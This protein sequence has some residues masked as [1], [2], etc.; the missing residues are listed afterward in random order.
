MKNITHIKTAF[1]LAVMLNL[2]LATLSIAQRTSVLY[3]SGTDKDHTKQWDFQ[4]DHGM[5]SGSWSKIAV[6][7]NWETQGFGVYKYGRED[8]NKEPIS[9]ETAIYRFQFEVPSDWKGRVIHIVFE[10][11]MTDTRVELNGKS[12]GP[13]HQGGFY[14]FAYDIT[15]LVN[16][17]KSNLLQVTVKNWSE[18]ESVNRSEREADFWI[19]GGIYR[20]V[21]LTAKPRQHIERLAIDA[22]AKGEFKVDVYLKNNQNLIRAEARVY[23]KDGQRIGDP[24]Y[25]PIARGQDKLTMAS[26]FRSA[27]SWSPEFPELYTV[28][29]TIFDKKSI[30]HS[31][32]ER[33]GFRTVE[34][35]EGEGFYVNGQKIMFKGVNRHSF[36]P[37]TGRCLSKEISI[38]DVTLMKAMNMN[39]VRMS[40]YP[41]DRHFLD[42]CDSMGLFVLDELTGWQDAY[43]TQVGEKLV[44]ELVIRD[45]NHPCVVAWDNGNEGG[46]N[47][48]LVDDYHL[49]D[50][51]KR[52]VI[53]PWDI[54]NGTDTNHYKDYDCCPG[55]LFH[56]QEVFFPTEFLHGLYD[57]GHGAGL[58]DHWNLMRSNPLSAGGF[59]WVLGD[60]GLVRLDQ[61]GRI[62][63][64][65]SNA[66]DGIL[67]PY[68]EKEGSFYAIKEIWSP[69]VVNRTQIGTNFDGIIE[70]ENRYHY[71]NL[72]QCG[73]EW[74]LVDYPGPDDPG[75]ASK[76]AL[77]NKVKLP[78]IRPGGSTAVQID[79]PRD[80]RQYDGLNIRFTDPYGKE[81]YTYTWP[82]RSP[83]GINGKLLRKDVQHNIAVD[84]RDDELEI[85]AGNVSFTFNKNT[86]MLDHVSSNKRTVSFGDGPILASGN[87]VFTGLEHQ[88]AEG[89]YL[90]RLH[91]DGDVKKAEFTISEEGLLTLDY[92]YLPKKGTYDFLGINFNYPEDKITAVKWLGRGPYRVW[93]NRMKGQSFGVWEKAYNNTIT[94]EKEWIYPEFKGY[95]SDLYWVKIENDEHPFTIYVD[96]PGMFFRLFTPEP[97]EGAYNENTDGLF[98]DGDIS[99][100]HA[101]SPI[102]TKFKRADQLGPQ[103]QKNIV[104][105]HGKQGTYACRLVFDFR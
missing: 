83:S 65:G 25:K 54:F 73:M 76:I 98:P 37:E 87:T 2:I 31:V 60:E 102:G 4:I 43:D 34:L 48:D 16:Y 79:L 74:E 62:D 28:E 47:H 45:V 105:Y 44:R 41:P 64:H 42:V 23:N 13:V 69:V 68:R 7:S 72:N 63:T 56:G 77:K 92:Q 99:F 26:F 5:N 40:H 66:P 30:A 85:T 20:P 93:K 75:T 27:E 17:G 49:Y 88:S 84:E 32:S 12:A 82:L 103:G 36:W 91:Y 15:G 96:S 53:H 94:G 81:L 61:D 57:G 58:E 71:T 51:Q 86:G 35:R 46:N 11:V 39:A 29:V 104:Q 33:F 52:P 70:I 59:L 14:E 95:H 22:R 3:L 6:P 55:M 97:P 1:I 67:G 24:I 9:N 101:I 90:V 18:N 8:R 50:P 21:Y 19:F 10:G 100:L 89:S 38:M 80:Y 78:D